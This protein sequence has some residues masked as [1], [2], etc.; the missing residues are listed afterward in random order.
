MHSVSATGKISHST[1]EFVPFDGDGQ[2]GTYVKDSDAADP[3]GTGSADVPMPASD[4]SEP[5]L[6]EGMSV[7]YPVSADVPMPSAEPAG[8]PAGSPGSSYQPPH[9]ASMSELRMRNLIT[10]GVSRAVGSSASFDDWR[11]MKG[12]DPSVATAARQ[13]AA[14]SSS[15]L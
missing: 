13:G 6:F 5:S 4:P 12:V 7:V 1:D 9:V 8:Q 14:A 11:P 2:G 10:Q 15:S 3:M